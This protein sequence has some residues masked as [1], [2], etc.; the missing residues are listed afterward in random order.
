GRV[1]QDAHI[2]GMHPAT[3]SAENPRFRASLGGSIEQAPAPGIDAMASYVE[4][5]VPQLRTHRGWPIRYPGKALSCSRHELLAGD[6][7]ITLDEVRQYDATWKYQKENSGFGA[8][9]VVWLE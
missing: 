4:F 2:T 7:K 6:W 9:H 8:T 1:I 5:L 3:M